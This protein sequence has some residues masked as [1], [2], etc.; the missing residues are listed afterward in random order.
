[1]N[2]YCMIIALALPVSVAAQTAVEAAAIGSASTAGAKP[3]QKVGRGISG[4]LEQTGRSLQ[5]AS[6]GPQASKSTARSVTASPVNLSRTPVPPAATSA[7][8]VS[9]AEATANYED[10]SNIREGM[11][12]GGLMHRFGPPALKLATGSTEETLCYTAKD[13]TTLDITVRDAKVIAVRKTGAPKSNSE[14]SIQ[15]D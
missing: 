4:V 12:A 6:K 11:D 7:P 10:P 3:A 1:M 2:V 13:G 9:E 5:G 14:V 15:Q 8:A